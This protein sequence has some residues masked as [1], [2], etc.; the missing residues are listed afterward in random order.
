[1][2]ELLF[3]KDIFIRDL[4]HLSGFDIR[5][6]LDTKKH[7]I[8]TG[9]NG[10]GKSTLLRAIND[11]LSLIPAQRYNQ[12]LDLVKLIK[13]QK[14]NMIKNKV[15]LDPE[16]S[17]NFN[18]LISNRDKMSSLDVTL[19]RR[20]YDQESNEVLIAYFDSKRSINHSLPKG[21]NKVDFK[22][23]YKPDDKLNAHFIQHIVNLKAERSFARDDGDDVSVKEIDSWFDKFQNSLRIILE[24]PDL[25]LVFERKEFNFSIEIPGKPK[26]KMTEM[27]DG[28]TA[29]LSVL[30]EIVMRM[31][32]SGGKSYNSP[33]IVL[34]DEIETH[35]HVSLQKK[36]LPSLTH[37]FPNVQFIVT[38]HSP[39]VLSSIKDSVIC[40]L[41][42]R[43]ITSD[44]SGYSYDALIE[45]YFDSNKYSNEL[46]SMVNKYEDYINNDEYD[47][48]EAE[49]IFSYLD[50]LPKYLTVGKELE[51]KIKMLEMKVKEKEFKKGKGA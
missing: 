32:I 27:S 14:E 23:K 31:D 42:K 45:S 28:H 37:F 36:I 13:N 26:F 44:L 18:K 20:I 24:E 4:R 5:L 8:I 49:K 29:I 7:L 21:I 15:E 2:A 22:E 3:I 40:D 34:I 50:S 38:T 33:G 1:M 6:H 35:L 46:I 11:F 12:Y 41:E 47:T 48:L 10:S 39:F 51:L 19:N 9:K 25:K 30:S 43:M 16:K 17:S